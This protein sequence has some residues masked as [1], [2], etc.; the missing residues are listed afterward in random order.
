MSGIVSTVTSWTP[1]TFN[2]TLLWQY[3]E[4][5]AEP[6]LKSYSQ[7]TKLNLLSLILSMSVLWPHYFASP[8]HLPILCLSSWNPIIHH[9]S[10]LPYL[11]KNNL[12]IYI[13]NSKPRSLWTSLPAKVLW[14]TIGKSY[15]TIIH[16]TQQGT[17]RKLNTNLILCGIIR[18]YMLRYLSLTRLKS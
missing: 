1:M 8:W 7:T 12:S 10:Y 5:D 3:Q 4:P 13:V 17:L 15:T 11:V 9:F 16:V 14:N 18:F 6:P 2:H